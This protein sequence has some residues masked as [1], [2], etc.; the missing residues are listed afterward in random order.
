MAEIHHRHR[1]THPLQQTHFAG[2]ELLSVDQPLPDLQTRL[3]Q[4]EAIEM[5]SPKIPHAYWRAI[6]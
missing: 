5:L 4:L 2:L 1:D 6:E 3:L